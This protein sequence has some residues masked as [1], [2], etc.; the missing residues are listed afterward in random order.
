MRDLSEP[1]TAKWPFLAGD[2]LLLSTAYVI[3]YQAKLPMGHWEI[4]FAVVCVATGAFLA[5]WPFVLDYRALVKLAESQSLTTAVAQLKNLEAIAGQIAGATAQWQTVQETAGK[6]VGGA[7]EIADRMTAEV[8]GFTEFLQRANDTEKTTLR[9]E[10][11]KLK[12][13]ENDW[14]QVL[15]RTL[16]HVYAL[17]QGGL[18]SG[19]PNLIEQLNHFQHACRDAARRIGLTPL[20]A[21]ADEPFDPKKH[22]AFEGDGKMPP[23]PLVVETIATGYN[24]Q[25]RMLRPILVRV[26]AATV[27]PES[28]PLDPALETPP[29]EPGQLPLPTE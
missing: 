11:E 10:V 14:L 4:L 25:G 22:Q 19:Q 2:A 28:A 9:L 3:Y 16:D 23:D 12:R 5:A 20:E 27:E 8:A 26:R 1:R 15:I 6:T 13:V 29:N 18:R 7:R 24:F 21:Q 17:H